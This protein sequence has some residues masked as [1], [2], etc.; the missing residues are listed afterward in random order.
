MCIRSNRQRE[1]IG[2]ALLTRLD[3]IASRCGCVRVEVTSGDRRAKEAHLF[4]QAC[5]YAI[6]SR[7][8]QKMLNQGEQDAR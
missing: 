1:G 7:R 2:R 5:G 4:Y 3:E 6:D 8:F